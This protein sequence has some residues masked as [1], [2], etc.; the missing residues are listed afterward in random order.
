[1]YELI[2]GIVTLILNTFLGL[3][4]FFRNPKSWTNKLLFLL[5]IWIDLYLVVNYLSLHPP[6][7]TPESQLLWIRIVMF[8]CS[9]IGPTLVLLIHTFPGDKIMLRKRFL[10]P[11]LVLCLTAASASLSHL[12]F[13]GIQYPDGQPVPI[14]G[15]MIPVF[16]LDFIGLFIFSFF[17]LIYKYR[18]SEGVVKIQHLYFLLGVF[19]TFTIMGF[20]TVVLVVLFKFSKLVFLGPNAMIFM[21]M[22]I[23]YAMVRHNFLD[24]RLIVARSVAYALVLLI[25]LL[26]YAFAIFLVGTY[27]I[28]YP[29]APVTMA[30]AVF[31]AFIIAISYEPLLRYVEQFT[32]RVFFK[33][34]YDTRFLLAKLGRIMASTLELEEITQLILKT[35]VRDIKISK[36]YLLLTRDKEIIWSHG[37]AYSHPLSLNFVGGYIDFLIESALHKKG[38][39][40]LLY[41]ELPE[42]PE[43]DIMKEYD[44]R[45]AFPL[46]VEKKP[47]GLMWFGNKLSGEIYS[48]EDSHLFKILASEIAV[49]INNSLQYD[50]IKKFNMTLQEK[51]KHDIL[52]T[53]TYQIKP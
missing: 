17:L 23:T 28:G 52:Q 9:F 21:V 30:I 7:P 40:V 24:I 4:S 1:M 18:R 19:L 39:E 31:F 44:M 35:L 3:F 5:T 6:L 37:Q 22:C 45:V 29:I 10:I 12:V 36:G 53:D 34:R 38:N 43:K 48:Q 49:A 33:H 26:S 8:V 11:L 42:S 51:I 27:I 41:D 16:F 47:I 46:I 50:E 25:L 32:D 2:I 15:P 13:S 14:P 20:T